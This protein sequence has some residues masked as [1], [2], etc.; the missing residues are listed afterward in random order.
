LG[1]LSGAPVRLGFD[2]ARE[3]SPWFYTHRISAPRTLHAAD[4][5]LLVARFLDPAAGAPAIGDFPLPADGE[6]AARVQHLLFLHG[7]IPGAAL[8]ALNPAAR[9]RTK[10]WPVASFAELADG[11]QKEGLRVLIVGDVS[12]RQLAEDLTRRMRTVPINLVGQ[13]SIKE[14]LALL[15]QV[16]LFVTND[17][18]PMHLAAALGVP[19]LALFG[20]TDPARTGPYG[21]R[22]LVL[23]SDVPCSPCFSRRCANPHMLECLTSIDPSMALRHALEILQHAQSN[24]ISD[25]ERI[26]YAD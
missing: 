12:D 8:V 22:H 18:G 17:S 15:R 19:I 4:R 10:Q 11:L 7:V 24:A 23:T 2:N 14:L 1:W 9:W 20:P 3:G 16:R 13:T 25:K 6:A 5:Y 21:S 26:S